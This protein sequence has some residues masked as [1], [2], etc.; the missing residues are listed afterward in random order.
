MQSLS[1]TRRNKSHACHTA[2]HG[3]ASVVGVADASAQIN[4]GVVEHSNTLRDRLVKIGQ[5]HFARVFIP[6]QMSI[7]TDGLL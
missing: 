2:I 7:V 1:Y 5:E 6:K 4:Q 3:S